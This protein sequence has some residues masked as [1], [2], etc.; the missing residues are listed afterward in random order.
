MPRPVMQPLDDFITVLKDNSFKTLEKKRYV[1]G[2]EVKRMELKT[3]L[4]SYEVD[5]SR[6]GE[7]AISK[8]LIG[9][10][11]EQMV[12]YASEWS[13]QFKLAGVG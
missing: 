3:F 1:T 7:T 12:T 10:L 9:E 2:L 8:G 6:H 13:A 5:M 11:K 4:L